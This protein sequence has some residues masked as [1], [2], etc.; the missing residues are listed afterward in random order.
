MRPLRRPLRSL[1]LRVVCILPLTAYC[2]LLSGHTPSLTVGLLPRVFSQN[3][4]AS[5]QPSPSPLPLPSPSPTP[6]PNLHQWGAVTSFH[7]L[8]SDRTHAIAQTE[9]GVTWF[10][11]DGGLARYDGRRTNAINAAGLPPGRVLALK[12]DESGALWI[13]TDNGAA[14]LA[15][16]RFETVKE[17]AGK[18]ITNII[19]PQPGRAIMASEGGQIFD[20]QVKP[21]AA[22]ASTNRPGEVDETSSFSVKT[23]PDQP[24]QSADKDHPGPLKING[25]ALVGEKLYA[26][27]QSRGLIVFENGE[28]HDVSSKPRSYFINALEVDAHGRLWTGARVRT[29][30]GGLFENDDPLKPTKANAATGPVTAIA[31]G[32]RD[33]VWIAT[34]GRGAFHFEDRKPT[35]HFTFEGSGGALRSDHIFGVFVD[36]EEV[37]WFATDKGV[38]RYDPHAMRVENI[39]GDPGTNYVR[40]LWRTSR[41]RLLAGT[42]SGLFS[43]DP[44]SKHW[45]AIPELGRRIIYA[46]SEDKNGRVLVASAGGLF[47]SPSATEMSFARAGAEDRSPQSDSVRAIVNAGGVT[48]IATF[49]YGIEKL[50]GPRRSLVW[51]EASA[52]EHWREVVSLGT[53]ANGSLVIGTAGAGAFVFDGK[54]TGTDNALDQLKGMGIWSVVNDGAEVWLATDKGLYLFNGG[55]LKEIVSGVNARAVV[56]AADSSRKQVWCGTLGSGL[57]KVALDDQFGAIVSRLDVEQGLPS[58]R[59]FAV[60]SERNSDGSESVIAG[61][62]RGLVRYEQGRVRP[63]VLPARIISQRIHEQSELASGL[64]LD[65]PQNSL[66]LDVTAI[67][68]RT[69]PEQFQ[70]AFALSDSS[71]KVIREKLSHDSQF[72]M[73]KLKPGNYKVV[74]RAFTK[75]LT[76]AT[77]LSFEFTVAR[78]PFPLTST[79]LGVLL[80]FALIAL[81]WGY[82]QNRRIHRTSAELASAN[83]ELA[84]AR[85][86]L[87]NETETER[88]R[89][90]RDLHDQT[91]AD[92]RNLALLVDQLPA[93][94]GLSVRPNRSP[95]APGALRT[96]IEL[97]SQ[98]VRRIC[99]DLS[100]SALEN[101]G[102]SAALQFALAHAVE[103]AAPDCKF[104]YE[105]ACDDGLDEKLNLP[106]SVQIQIYRVTQEA[107]SNICRHAKARHVKMSVAV[108]EAGVFD[109]R[110][111]DDGLGFDG[112]GTKK[113]PGRGVANMRARASMIDAEVDWV[114]RDGGGTMFTLYK[115]GVRASGE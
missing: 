66:L 17:T 9:F 92:L 75:D 13:G 33:D 115:K 11:T 19:T 35:E 3:Q 57:M 112:S 32:P 50:D 42:N 44:D 18:V 27:T 76:E 88:R 109:L 6:P 90:A 45:R 79:A 21:A 100:P 20:C 22:A 95:S 61:T 58:Q 104:E 8:P 10:A 78:A 49:G 39:T 55:K 54:R 26:G 52:D 71:G 2:L 14:R 46:I 69:F 106:S 101:V 107:L 73:E 38:C 91:L 83:R 93:S 97:I 24:L 15:N 86:Q 94:G 62:N 30:D 23:I 7:G 84:D 40:T 63:T 74:A 37:V 34:D 28:A 5:P 59:V 70:Y 64:K 87:A 60:L 103:H 4:T 65:F 12:T 96:E 77:P 114:K 99:E 113:K 43:Y 67:S 111:E 89:I 72:A 29:E 102:L 80:L 108:T 82:F 98:E 105:F 110:I 48:Y 36:S 51:P 53:D 81:G 31:R 1:R 68:S 16:A 56:V 85:L 25:L 41:G 47:A